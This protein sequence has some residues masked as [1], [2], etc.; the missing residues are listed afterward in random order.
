MHAFI[1]CIYIFSSH[2][3]KRHE[4][5]T[6]KDQL[7]SV[8][9]QKCDTDGQLLRAHEEVARWRFEALKSRCIIANRESVLL[10]SGIAFD[11]HPNVNAE[12]QRIDEPSAK[13][14]ISIINRPVTDHHLQRQSDNKENRSVTD[15]PLQRQSDDKKNV[16]VCSNITTTKLISPRKVLHNSTHHNAIS[17]LISPETAA[18]VQSTD[19]SKI[20]ESDT[21]CSVMDETVCGSASAI[22]VTERKNIITKTPTLAYRKISITPQ[23]VAQLNRLSAAALKPTPTKQ[24]ILMNNG[25]VCSK[26]IEAVRKCVNFSD[27]TKDDET[28]TA[29]VTTKETEGT[30]TTFAQPVKKYMKTFYVK[31]KIPTEW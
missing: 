10:E 1:D 15:H 31:G 27:D 21:S 2:N 14:N 13:P 25:P 22:S 26:G 30:G 6:L 23:R 7:Y 5:K 11:L 4:T 29:A 8:S 3:S 19:V 28:E 20:E 18:E 24:S 17:M 12:I 16:N 9:L